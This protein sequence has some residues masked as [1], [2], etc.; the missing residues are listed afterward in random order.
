M[1]HHPYAREF[2]SQIQLICPFAY[3]VRQ[4][5][6]MTRWILYIKRQ[7]PQAPPWKGGDKVCALSFVSYLLQAIVF[8]CGYCL[9]FS[10]EPC[11]L[12]SRWPF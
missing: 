8:C 7:P 3:G 4:R 11:P 6:F 5:C 1:V 12:N 10:V 2:L 9:S